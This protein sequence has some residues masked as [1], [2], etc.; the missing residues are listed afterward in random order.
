MINLRLLL[1]ALLPAALAAAPAARPNVLMIV[2]DDLNDWVGHLGGHPQVRTP[3]LDALA[4]RPDRQPTGPIDMGDHLA[5][6]QIIDH[7]RGFA[8]RHL[9]QQP[10]AGAAVVEAEDQTRLFGRAT[11]DGGRDAAATVIAPQQGRLAGNEGKARVPHQ[12]A[13]GEHP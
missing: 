12:R 7:G 3:H 5:R 10:T 13:I 8:R 6:P 9:E 1:L 11:V 2:L 4:A